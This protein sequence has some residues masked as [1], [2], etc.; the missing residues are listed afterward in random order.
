MAKILLVEDEVDLADTIVEW[1]SEEYHLVEVEAHGDIALQRLSTGTYDLAILDV[2][3]PGMNGLNIC[4]ALR[5][6]GAAIPVLMLT[7]RKSIDAKEAGLDAGAD[8][9]LTKPFQLR[10]LSARIRALL[11]RPQTTP[12]NILTVGDLSLDRITCVVTKSGEPIHLLPKEF[13]LLELFMRNVGK[14]ISIDSLLDRVWGTDSSIVPETVRTN[15]KTLRKKID[16][17]SGASY[18]HTVHGQGYKMEPLK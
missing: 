10:E 4:R 17:P 7:A 12:S 5:Q 11:R 9:Y 13:A 6:S 3:L 16:S 1:L 8:D 18:I 2:M 14:V 15:I